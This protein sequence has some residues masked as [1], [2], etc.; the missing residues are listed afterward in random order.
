MT[1]PPRCPLEQGPTRGSCPAPGWSL[2]QKQPLSG[3]AAEEGRVPGLLVSSASLL[4]G[5]TFVSFSISCPLL[6][7]ASESPSRTVRPGASPVLDSSV[8]SWS[9][10]TR[11]VTVTCLARCQMLPKVCP[12]PCLG[13]LLIEMEWPALHK[14][15]GQATNVCRHMTNK[16]LTLSYTKRFYKSIIKYMNAAIKIIGQR[17]RTG[18]ITKEEVEIVNMHMRRCLTSLVIKEIQ[19]KAA[20]RSHFFHFSNRQIFQ[21]GCGEMATLVPC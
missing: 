16:G 15:K 14:L 6:G 3:A 13:A 7:D 2:L 5:L 17:T 19:I 4:P 12:L 18:N 8:G 1:L 21:G 20:M 10:L 9:L 11:V